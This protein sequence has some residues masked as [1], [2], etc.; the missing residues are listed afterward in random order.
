VFFLFTYIGTVK[1]SYPTTLS[2][3]I[4]ELRHGSRKHPQAFNQ[5]LNETSTCKSLS[6]SS[7]SLKEI[8]RVENFCAN[9]LNVTILT[10]DNK[11]LLLLLLNINIHLLDNL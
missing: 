8:Y 3:D 9:V 4:E 7:R 10:I 6:L 1:A 11:S 5:G 2:K